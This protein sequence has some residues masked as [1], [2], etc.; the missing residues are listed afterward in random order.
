LWNTLKTAAKI[1]GDMVP[2]RKKWIWGILTVSLAFAARAEMTDSGLYRV[3]KGEG[4]GRVSLR[5]YGTTRRW[6]EIAELNELAGPHFALRE[7]QSLRLPAPPTLSERQGRDKMVAYWLKRDPWRSGIDESSIATEP[8]PATRSPALSTEKAGRYL[9]S[10]RMNHQKYFQRGR[11]LMDA[12]NY[13]EALKYFAQSRREK[14]D[15]LPAWFYALRTHQLKKDEKGW[16]A[17][18]KSLVEK[19][20]HLR[21]LPIFEKEGPGK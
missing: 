17:L 14:E 10:Q 13:D 6:K 18:Q 12:G 2:F 5:L 8:A 4:L 15:Y 16:E 21:S 9:A 3:Q 1:E 19:Y 11:E 7:G 20:P